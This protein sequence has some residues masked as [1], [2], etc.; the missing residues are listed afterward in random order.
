MRLHD[1][2]D[3]PSWNAFVQRHA[4]RS[5]SFLQTAEWGS[6]QA[7]VGK[8]VV[9]VGFFDR[10]NAFSSDQMVMSAQALEYALPM[11]MRYLYI[12][13]GP[14][15][16]GAVF[17]TDAYIRALR[18]LGERE[19]AMFVRFEPP[20]ESATPM[21]WKGLARTHEVQPAHTFIT[22]ISQ[23]EERMLT[24]MHQKTRYNIRLAEKKGVEVEIGQGSFNEVWEMFRHTGFR[25]AFHLHP[26]AYYETMLSELD[27]GFARAYLA[28]ARYKEQALAANIMIDSA[29]TRTYLH[30]ASSN[31]HRNLMAPYLLHWRLMQ[32]AHRAGLRWYDWWG[33]APATAGEH[34]PW[35]GITRFKLGFGGSRVSYPGT[36]DLVLQP[37]KYHLYHTLRHILRKVR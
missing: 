1:I 17:D 7:R 14:L 37:T 4:P 22:D 23:G 16:A 11:W 3:R 2:T 34:H 30:G 15:V 24:G 29:G 32:D 36:F 25:G 12:P 26:R 31:E 19:G 20:T 27:G 21:A 13:R 28:V 9:R 18:E 35:S 8:R 10:E 33:V 6:F 5:G